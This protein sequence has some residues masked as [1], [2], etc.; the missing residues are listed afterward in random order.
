M[1]A[2][3][4]KARKRKLR[5]DAKTLGKYEERLRNR[6]KEY[7]QAFSGKAVN[8]RRARA[9]C[10]GELCLQARERLYQLKHTKPLMDGTMEFFVNEEKIKDKYGKRFFLYQVMYH[11]FSNENAYTEEEVQ[12]ELNIF[13]E[14]LMRETDELYPLVDPEIAAGMDPDAENQPCPPMPKGTDE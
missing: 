1:T 8:N 2:K 11:V 6:R 12:K 10:V 3:E 7:V 5:E 9:L 4:E 14:Q 13:R